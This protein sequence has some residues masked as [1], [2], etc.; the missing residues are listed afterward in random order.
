MSPLE[1][2]KNILKVAATI[3]QDTDEREAFVHSLRAGDH[4]ISAVAWLSEKPKHLPFQEHER[5]PQW[6]PQWIDVASHD[7]R[8]GKLAEHDDG[9]FYVLD[10]SSTFAL[11]P[12]ELLPQPVGCLIDVCAAPGGKGIVGRRY[13]APQ[14]VIANEVIGKRTAPLISNYRRCAIDPAMIT[15]CD[16]S[17]LGRLLE[18]RGDLVIVDAPCSG[19]S[20]VLKDLAAPGAF[21]P[22]TIAM[23]ERRQRRILAH[24][25]KMVAPGGYLL[26]ATCTFSVEENEKNIEWFVKQFPEFSPLRVPALSAYTSALSQMPVYRLYPQHGFGAGAFCCLLQRVGQPASYQLDYTELPSL[27][28]PVWSSLSIAQHCSPSPRPHRTNSRE[29]HGDERGQRKA[30]R[31]RGRRGYSESSSKGK[32]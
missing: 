13:C 28:R 23:N 11:A 8:P 21:H 9:L 26:Y 1:L 18:A 32:K 25:A 17:L 22:A 24:S 19:Q 15:S 29:R 14:A 3:F 2:S 30:G 5:R 31:W 12:L 27:V 4:G 10:L 7:T 6:L 20:L 16:P